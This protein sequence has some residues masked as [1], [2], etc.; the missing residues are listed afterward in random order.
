[1]P[2]PCEYIG[3]WVDDGGHGDEARRGRVIHHVGERL[4][5]LAPVRTAAW[6]R[7]GRHEGQPGQAGDRDVAAVGAGAERAVGVL[8]LA[9]QASPL[10]MA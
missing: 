6:A 1:M 10:W 5:D 4:V 3:P 2:K 8:R 9:S 7:A